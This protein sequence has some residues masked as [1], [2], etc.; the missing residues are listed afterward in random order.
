MIFGPDSSKALPAVMSGVGSRILIVTGVSSF[1]NMPLRDI[2]CREMKNSSINYFELEVGGE[3][4]TDFIDENASYYREKNINAVVSIGGGSVIDAGKAISGMIPQDGPVTCYLEG[5]GIKKH[6]G[7]KVPFIAVPTTAGTGSEATKNA[8]LTKHGPG[9]YKKSLRH[10]NLVPDVAVID[11]VLTIGC[12]P[13]ITAACGMDAL[14]QLIESFLSAQSSFLTDTLSLKGISLHAGRALFHS[15]TDKV[16]DILTR[17][18]LAY[19][20]YLSG[21]VLANAGL[22]AV[23]GLAGVI[24]GV[25]DIPHG[26]ICAS[27]LS[28]VTDYNI[29]KLSS[30]KENIALEKYSRAGYALTGQEPS[31][32]KTGCSILMEYLREMTESLN[33]QGIQDFKFN[34]D[35][36]DFISEKADNKNNPVNLTPEDFHNILSGISYTVAD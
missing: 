16:S 17:S 22:G 20:A 25:F 2:L 6:N 30:A 13:D 29:E 7:I 8:V 21:V 34:K 11:P 31:D 27:L 3:P 18:D 15:C 35:E 33:I 32:I 26:I 19:A 4:T 24:G 23:H 1:K 28:K 36:I 9:G 5:V 10:D 12:P 14:T